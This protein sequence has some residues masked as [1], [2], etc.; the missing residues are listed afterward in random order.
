MSY[1][2]HGGGDPPPLT[3]LKQ[4]TMIQTREKEILEFE[5][6]DGEVIGRLVIVDNTTSWWVD[7][8][9]ENPVMIPVTN[10]TEID[11]GYLIQTAEGTFTM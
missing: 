9:E 7:F 5:N 8:E 11:G 1:Y 6:L 10:W 2:R 4:T 3:N